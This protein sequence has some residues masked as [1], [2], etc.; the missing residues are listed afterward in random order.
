MFI[1]YLVRTTT[2]SPTS[3]T[4]TIPTLEPGNNLYMFLIIIRVYLFSCFCSGFLDCIVDQLTGYAGDCTK[5]RR[6]EMYQNQPRWINY[7][8][9]KQW[10]VS[11]WFQHSILLFKT[12]YFSMV[13]K[14]CVLKNSNLT[15]Y[16]LE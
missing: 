8:C 7:S 3:T 13:S 15:C 2:S 4:V 6:C 11:A 12:Q 14:T 16:I 10:D 9:N 5:Y 1:S